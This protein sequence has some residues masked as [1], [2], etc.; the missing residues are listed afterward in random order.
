M[1]DLIHILRSHYNLIRI[2][3]IRIK[4]IQIKYNL[5]WTQSDLIH[6]YLS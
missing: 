3:L 2:N 4:L 5:L 6:I 1:S